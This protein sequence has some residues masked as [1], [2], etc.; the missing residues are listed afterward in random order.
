MSAPS[1][2][3]AAASPDSE[4]SQPPRIIYENAPDASPDPYQTRREKL[5]NRRG[6]THAAARYEDVK[7]TDLPAPVPEVVPVPDPTPAQQQAAQPVAAPQQAAETPPAAPPVKPVKVVAKKAH[8]AETQ[9][10]AEDSAEAAPDTSRLKVRIPNPEA[11]RQATAPAAVA[12]LKVLDQQLAKREPVQD[13]APST[14]PALPIKQAVEPAAE[15]KPTVNAPVA[16]ITE[17]RHKKTE[18][19]ITLEGTPSTTEAPA[20]ALAQ[21]AVVGASPDL[22]PQAPGPVRRFMNTLAAPF[23]ASL[24]AVDSLFEH[25]HH[26]LVAVADRWVENE[27]MPMLAAAEPSPSAYAQAPS[28]PA[29]PPAAEVPREPELPSMVLPPVNNVEMPPPTAQ[30][31]LTPPPA[32]SAPPLPANLPALPTAQQ[33]AV[34]TAPTQSA[35]A[36]AYAQPYRTP[37]AP[38]SPQP[39]VPDPVAS[40]FGADNQPVMIYYPPPQYY[41]QAPAYPP[42]PTYPPSAYPPQ[43]YPQQA[44][45]PQYPQ[46]YAQPYPQ[47]VYAQVPSAP[48]PVAPPVTYTQYTQNMPSS[49]PP[50]LSNVIA[51]SPAPVFIVERS[52]LDGRSGQAQMHTRTAVVS[53]YAQLSPSAGTPDAAP[54]ANPPAA[55]AP[56]GAAIPVSAT[57]SSGGPAPPAKQNTSIFEASVMVPGGTAVSNAPADSASN[58]ATASAAVAAAPPPAAVPQV[59]VPQVAVPAASPPTPA[60]AP[61][62][63]AAAPQAPPANVPT[64]LLGTPAAPAAKDASTEPEPALAPATKKTLD[65]IPSG[66]SKPK[67]EKTEHLVVE[68]HKHKEEKKAGDAKPGDANQPAT[69]K[70]PVAETK[71]DLRKPGLDMQYELEQAYNALATGDTKAAIYAYSTVLANEPENKSALFGLATAYHRV[72]QL[73][74]ARPYYTH[75]LKIDPTNR[76]ALNNFLALAGEEAPQEALQ[77]LDDLQKRN[78]DFGPIPAQKAFIYQKLGEND[79]AIDNMQK[80]MELEPANLTYRYNLAILY[81]K[82]GRGQDAI[83]LYKQIVAASLRGEHIPGSIDRVQQRLT[84]LSSN[85]A[86]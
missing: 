32:V 66:I 19:K 55:A 25:S 7:Q 52:T 26:V 45:A 5:K 58:A 43:A 81:D 28:A 18:E 34:A 35:P 6:K 11:V 78:P 33:P 80:A 63:A 40:V 2:H 16:S 3:A 17:V 85:R 62:P 74:K 71:I 79:Q 54:P 9:T 20:A 10:A 48:A 70:P 65:A 61:A 60:A 83:P 27:K 67:P 36:Y 75:L 37:A 76:D 50:P 69:P 47:P 68:H 86:Q 24:S 56:P 31:S 57:T 22:S 21:K 49:A 38:P 4:A 64:P 1:W 46:Q 77:E 84:F 23:S 30:A 39:Y 13:D 42:Q 15:S 29:A 59:A 82:A 44:Y 51:S 12:S 14:A 72:G 8:K 53:D 41:V 73:E